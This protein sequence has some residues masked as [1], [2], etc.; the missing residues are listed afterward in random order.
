MEKRK[1][2]FA[3]LYNG[4]KDI[5]QLKLFAK[6]PESDP[7]WF[8]FLITLSDKADFTRNDLTEYLEANK[9][10]TRNLFAGNILKHPCFETL[11][12]G[13]DY[14]VAGSLT[15]T[16]KIMNDSLWIGLYPGMGEDKLDYMI[17]T[18]RNFCQK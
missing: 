18:I 15:N 14:R 17:S 4:L 16:D 11:A 9:I 5:P 13:V 8:G 3:R 6:Y 10:Q 1:E 12:E 7:S 2:N